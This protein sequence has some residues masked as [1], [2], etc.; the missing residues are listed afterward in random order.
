M[1]QEQLLTSEGQELADRGPSFLIAARDNPEVYFLHSE[2]S[3]MIEPVA[4]RGP[5]STM[6]PLVA[7]LPSMSYLPMFSAITSNELTVPKSF[8]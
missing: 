6:H 3:S 1:F 4:H 7:V 5:Y 2:G 8:S